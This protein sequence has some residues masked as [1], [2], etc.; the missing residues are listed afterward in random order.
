MQDPHKVLSIN[1]SFSTKPY[2]L[3]PRLTN[4]LPY[5]D[6]RKLKE[7]IPILVQNGLIKDPSEDCVFRL[8]R[9]MI[10]NDNL[11]RGEKINLPIIIPRLEWNDIDPFSY[12][13]PVYIPDW[14][15]GHDR[16][17]FLQYIIYTEN[18]TDFSL[19]SINIKIDTQ[20]DPN[21]GQLGFHWQS[22]K[23]PDYPFFNN[24]YRY[25]NIYYIWYQETIQMD[26]TSLVLT[27]NEF[28]EQILLQACSTIK[29]NASRFE[30]SYGR[31]TITLPGEFNFIQMSF[32][33]NKY[34]I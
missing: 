23:L 24:A 26:E 8:D 33:K 10:I 9:M 17:I 3:F 20:E 7:V 16:Y 32:N 6:V 5:Y 14:T 28:G 34:K 15:G 13:L 1:N 19:S 21:F 12:E 31:G 27:T 25:K 11:Q 22:I 29:R 4:E 18:D 2:I 30:I